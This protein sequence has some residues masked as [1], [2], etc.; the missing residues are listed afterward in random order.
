LPTKKEHTLYIPA[1]CPQDKGIWISL[2]DAAVS[3]KTSWPALCPLSQPLDSAPTEAV[4]TEFTILSLQNEEDDDRMGTK[5]GATAG[6]EKVLANDT[7][8][9]LLVVLIVACQMFRESRTLRYTPETCRLLSLLGN[10]VIPINNLF[11]PPIP[12]DTA[13]IEV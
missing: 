1:K 5:M 8:W 11:T 4:S 9:Y 7:G 10:K 6:F 13:A 2:N 3:T 12:H